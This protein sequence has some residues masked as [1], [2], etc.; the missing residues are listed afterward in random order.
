MEWICAFLLAVV[1]TVG[2]VE[3]MRRFRFWLLRPLEEPPLVV[4]LRLENE[5][6]C[7]YQLRAVWERLRWLRLPATLRVRCL[8]PT[9]SPFVQ[10]VVEKF[11]AR[12]QVFEYERMENEPFSCGP[13]EGRG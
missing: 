3:L 9:G 2:L 11:A 1:F 5:Q 12:H 8:N 4:L 10:R 6:E 7:E 13:A